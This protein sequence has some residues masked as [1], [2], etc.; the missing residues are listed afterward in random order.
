MIEAPTREGDRTAYRANGP[1][2]CLHCKDEL[3]T[4]TAALAAETALAG[5]DRRVVRVPWVHGPGGL[6]CDLVGGLRSGRF[7]IV[8][9]GGN[10]R[11]NTDR[12]RQ[13]AGTFGAAQVVLRG[14][15][16]RP[17]FVPVA[18]TTRSTFDAETRDACNAL[19]PGV[20]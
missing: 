4:V 2:R 7:R 18:P 3:L 11:A 5:S 14:Q 16:L 12:R 20:I 6:A 17:A 8:G 10:A 19:H 13:W 9:P 15:Q 1:D